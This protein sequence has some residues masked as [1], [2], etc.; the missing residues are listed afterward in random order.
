V[1]CKSGRHQT[2]KTACPRGSP[3]QARYR[4]EI[5]PRV[6]ALNKKC[7]W[8]LQSVVGKGS[9][10]KH[11]PR[12]PGRTTVVASTAYQAIRTLCDGRRIPAA[13]RRA[14]LCDDLQDCRPL[15]FCCFKRLAEP[16]V[17][18]RRKLLFLVLQRGRRRG[19]PGAFGAMPS[20]GLPPRYSFLRRLPG[21]LWKALASYPA[22]CS[23]FSLALWSDWLLSVA[24]RLRATPRGRHVF[25]ALD[26]EN[27]QQWVSR[28]P[29]L[30][31]RRCRRNLMVI[32]GTYSLA[33]AL[34]GLCRKKTACPTPRAPCFFALDQEIFQ[35]WVISH[36]GLANRRARG[37]SG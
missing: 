5:G 34:H 4:C 19:R 23:G 14:K 29:R 32:R 20:S 31:N 26:Q 9:Q 37:T 17:V 12:D 16:R 8:R 1:R 6:R 28:H 3:G 36:R 2:L 21:L 11:C 33:E 27:L 24:K 30:A 22:P 7:K 13:R 35:Q 25:F 18:S 15:Q 10:V